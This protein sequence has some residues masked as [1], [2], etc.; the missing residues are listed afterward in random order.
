MD[1]HIVPIASKI[2]GTVAEVMIHDNETVKAGQVLVRIDPRDFQA[3]VDQ[4]KAALVLSQARARGGGRG[5]PADAGNH[6][7]HN[8]RRRC[9]TGRSPGQLRQV[10]VHI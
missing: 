7:Q 1:G 6:R 3:R 4:A 8:L 10:Q 9:A 5:R 2:S